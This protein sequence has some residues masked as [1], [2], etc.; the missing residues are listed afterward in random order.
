MKE[1]GKVLMRQI[2]DRQNS[3]DLQKWRLHVLAVKNIRVRF[4]KQ[5]GKSSA[6]PYDWVFGDGG[7]AETRTVNTRL[8]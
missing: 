5:P 6:N 7:K 1:L 4:A 2:V 8:A 3:L